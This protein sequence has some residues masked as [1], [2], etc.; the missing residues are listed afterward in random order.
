MSLLVFPKL[1]QVDG[2]YNLGDIKEKRPIGFPLDEGEL[3]PYSTLFHW[4]YLRAEKDGQISEH[5]HKGFEICTFVLNGEIEH[6]D[7]QF[8]GWKKLVAGDVQIIRLGSGI[9]HAEKL[10]KGTEIIQIWFDP[11]L[12]KS[13]N[14]EPI[15]NNYSSVKFPI[16]IEKERTVIIYKGEGS[17]VNLTTP[18]IEI[19]EYSFSTKEHEIKIGKKRIMS[20]FV[21][22]GLI[23]LDEKKINKSDFFIIRNQDSAILKC[24]SDVRLFVV[25]S[26]QKPE[27]KTYAEMN[28]LHQKF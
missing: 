12:S 28:N 8:K 5:H 1:K 6:Y 19:M 22:E 17:P 16:I 18:D 20:A 23:Y 14:R 15:C 27:Y 4:A 24:T 9:S 11:D 3:K 10:Y 21:I 2:D 26:P 25:F 7:N 13:I